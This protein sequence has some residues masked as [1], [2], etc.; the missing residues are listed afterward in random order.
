MQHPLKIMAGIAA[1]GALA[2]CMETAGGTT[3]G[4][5]P[6]APGSPPFITN[7]APDVSSA[8]INSCRAELDAQTDGAV[9]VVGGETSQANTAIYMRVGSNGAPWRC[10]VSPDGRNPS[11]MFMGSEGYL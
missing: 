6:V 4:Q 3:S 2:G 11:L 9:T 5:M 7:M 1:L 8:A 10:L